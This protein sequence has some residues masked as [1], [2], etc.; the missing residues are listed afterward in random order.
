ME[1]GFFTAFDKESERI[2][3]PNTDLL[4]KSPQN[5]KDPVLSISVSKGPYQVAKVIKDTEEYQ[6]FCQYEFISGQ[7]IDRTTD[8]GRPALS[9]VGGWGMTSAARSND[10]PYLP[11]MPYI[12]EYHYYLDFGEYTLSA[13]LTI[14]RPSYYRYGELPAQLV[15]SCEKLLKS[16]TLA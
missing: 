8:L 16:I 3:I 9:T 2:V 4:D 1:G 12:Y 6:T 13:Y 5:G 7:L 15:E 14:P 11:G 10:N